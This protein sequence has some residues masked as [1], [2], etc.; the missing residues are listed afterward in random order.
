MLLKDCLT[1]WGT[2]MNEIVDYGNR[3]RFVPVVLYSLDVV[4]MT[5]FVTI[6]Y[7]AKVPFQV[8]FL[9]AVFVCA[10]FVL[11]HSV[12]LEAQRWSCYR[13]FRRHK[14]DKVVKKSISVLDSES[15]YSILYSSG[16]RRVGSDKSV[17]FYIDALALAC[18]EDYVYA[19]RIGKYLFGYPESDDAGYEVT[20]CVNK[21][22]K[23]SKVYFVCIE[24]VK[25]NA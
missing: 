6:L 16:Y 25:S 12:T 13:F 17:D 8:Y 11:A 23:S 21:G 3:K 4:A 1:L 14:N 20:F 22:I 24:E 7:K 10:L 5:L 9:L 19:E 15:L 18:R 2:N